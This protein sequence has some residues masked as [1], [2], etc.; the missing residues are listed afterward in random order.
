MAAH[1]PFSSAPAREFARPAA[2]RVRRNYWDNSE[3]RYALSVSNEGVCGKVWRP[4][5]DTMTSDGV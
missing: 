4:F 2:W 3:S 5:L 1:P